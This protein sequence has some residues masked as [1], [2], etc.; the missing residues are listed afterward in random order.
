MT[1]L[2]FTISLTLLLVLTACGGTGIPTE[3][4]DSTSPDATQTSNDNATGSM[5]VEPDSTKD[6]GTSDASQTTNDAEATGDTTTAPEDTEAP[7]VED[8][9]V[10]APDV[11]P[12]E[13]EEP[14]EDWDGD[15]LTNLQEAYIGSDPNNADTD[16]D[17]LSDLEEFTHG[18]SVFA[19]DSDS[20]GVSDADEV[21][22]GTNPVSADTD[23]DG[24]SDMEEATAGTDPLL[25]WAW[26]F[27]G[28]QWPDMSAFGETAYPSGWAQGD[29]V[30]EI[31]MIDQFGAALEVARFH[32]YVVLLDFSAGWCVP[33]RNAAEE[34]QAMWEL[35]RDDGFMIIHLLIEGNVPGG[36]TTQGLQNEWAI[37]Y[38]LDFPVTR[39][40]AG[41]DVYQTFAEKSGIYPGSLP[42]IVLLDRDMRIDSGFGAGQETAMEARI[43]E[44]LEA[45]VSEPPTA[46]THATDLAADVICDAD[47]DGSRHSSCGGGDC[48][49]G[50]SSIHPDADELCD[51]VDR[52]CDGWHHQGAVDAQTRYADTDG[53]GYGSPEITMMSCGIPW[54]YVDNADDCNDGD[55]TINPDTIWYLDNDQDGLGNPEV[56]MVSCEQP[57]GYVGNDGDSD[58]SDGTSLGCWDHITVGRDHSCGLKSDGSIACWGCN[59]NGQHNA[60]EGSFVAIDSGMTHTCAIDAAGAVSCW[61]SNTSNSLNAPDAVF[62][63]I[64]CGLNYCCGITDAASDNIRC[65]GD[66]SYAQATP[67]PGTYVQVSVGN[68]RHTCAVDTAGVMSCWGFDYGQTGA[69]SPL[70][71]PADAEGEVRIGHKYTM[72]LKSDG[73]AIGWG[74]NTAGQATPPDAIFTDIRGGI[75]HS[76]GLR[77]DGSLICWGSNTLGRTDSPPGDG[78]TQIDV[79]QLHSC[80]LGSDGL[81]ECWGSGECH[82]DFCPGNYEC[83]KM[84]I[85]SCN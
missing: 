49:D 36:D 56:T 69:A 57:D 30:P 81:V 66:N 72:A 44:L 65:W 29:T 43:V 51:M 76:C 28:E 55:E 34:A 32:G 13:V 62:S 37:Q 16:A 63:S 40:P 59:T 82:E 19:A 39:E 1:R 78:F 2:S 79:G 31:A 23:G 74:A 12:D 26:P 5:D 47:Q 85:P 4:S 24:F 7:E 54:P 33:C 8:I 21:S 60:P 83:G 52:D 48:H 18:S 27:G 71:V 80:A 45:P 25:R 77:D 15:G 22:A 46:P 41:K 6:P 53:D 38:G 58:D 14:N 9:I 20:D 10:P 64:A 3:T 17:G 50:D 70:A 73:S 35:H 84:V 75:V 42:F 11:N 67:P 68:S 61:G